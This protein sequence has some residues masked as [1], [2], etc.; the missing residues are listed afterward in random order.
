MN[1]FHKLTTLTAATCCL[2]SGSAGA[3][4]SAVAGGGAG[5]GC[6]VEGA[7]DLVSVT[8][9]GKAESMG[10]WRQRKLVAHGQHM[11]IAQEAK[12]DTLPLRTAADSLRRLMIGGGGGAYSVRGDTYTEQLEFFYDPQLV[13][14]SV[15]A[16]CRIEGDQWYHDFEIAVNGQT[17]RTSEVWR[18][19]R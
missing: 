4:D 15:T 7:W 18:R 14:R 11:W 12:R 9:N 3:Q 17:T 16:K 13:G 8:A 19:V 6:A 10:G 1:A 2:L 5:R